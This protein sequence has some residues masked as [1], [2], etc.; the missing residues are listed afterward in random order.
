MLKRFLILTFLIASTSPCLAA[1][2][3]ELVAFDSALEESYLDKDDASGP[4][5]VVARLAQDLTLLAGYRASNGVR[6]MLSSQTVRGR[7][8]LRITSV[9]DVRGAPRISLAHTSPVPG[10][11]RILVMGVDLVPL[12]KR[13]GSG[14][15]LEGDEVERLRAFVATAHG[16][17]LVEAIPALY[18]AL[19]ESHGDEPWLSRVLMPF[20]MLR[21]LIDL[22][23]GEPAGFPNAVEVLGHSRVDALQAACSSDCLMRG[24]GFM[25][26]PD[27]LFDMLSDHRPAASP[28]GHRRPDSPR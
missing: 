9:R 18:V 3:S 24:K 11:N 19:A 4:P 10:Q 28:A 13:A 20:G 26:L 17:A 12:A 25:I 5:L 14:Q 6:L 16:Q 27:G 21:T 2:P 7:L 23:S 8:S 15:P 22:A 1:K